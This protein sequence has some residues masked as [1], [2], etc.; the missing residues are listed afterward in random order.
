MKFTAFLES[1][2]SMDPNLVEAIQLAYEQTMGQPQQQTAAPQQPSVDQRQPVWQDTLKGE[3]VQA[4][5]TTIRNFITNVN[6]DE[7]SKAKILAQNNMQN[8]ANDIV[9]HINSLLQQ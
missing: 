6:L 9:R 2:R 4:L 8:L 5:I 3:I 7:E 1:V